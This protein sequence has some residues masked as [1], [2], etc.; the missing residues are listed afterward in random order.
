LISSEDKTIEVDSDVMTSDV[1]VALHPGWNHVGGPF[2]CPVSWA[3]VKSRNAD[4]FNNNIV[5]D[6]LWGYNSDQFEYFLSTTLDPWQGYWVY[7]ST[8]SNVDLI[9]PYQ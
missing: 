7:N 9:I 1:T 6:V 3:D 5:A 2:S 4:L 8:G